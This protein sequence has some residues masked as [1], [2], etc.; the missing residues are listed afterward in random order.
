MSCTRLRRGSGNIEAPQLAAS[1]SNVSDSFAKFAAISPPR[2]AFFPRNYL[3][4]CGNRPFSD[5]SSSGGVE[6]AFHLVPDALHGASAYADFAGDFDNA[7]SGP[8]LS[9]DAPFNGLAY[10]RPTDAR[11]ERRL[12]KQ[13]GLR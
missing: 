1:L 11:C 12:V 10:L 5:V 7:F 3:R 4:S 9:L 13:A 8:Q 2:D 6:R